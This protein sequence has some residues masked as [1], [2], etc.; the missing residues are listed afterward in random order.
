MSRH[1]SADY[2]CSTIVHA[3]YANY[4]TICWINYI[5]RTLMLCLSKI[6]TSKVSVLPAWWK[7]KLYINMK[8]QLAYVVFMIVYIIY[9]HLI[10]KQ[11]MQ[12]Y[13]TATMSYY[14]LPIG[15][16]AIYVFYNEICAT[17]VSV[18][19]LQPFCWKSSK[20]QYFELAEC[21]LHQASNTSAEIGN[22]FVYIT[23]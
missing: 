7:Y 3:R 19:C 23:V 21:F 2:Q 17:T 9:Y 15:M 8:M 13:T 18:Q 4:S 16:K 11:Y 10:H 6:L 20:A 22:Y 1:P 14:F 12:L 5:L